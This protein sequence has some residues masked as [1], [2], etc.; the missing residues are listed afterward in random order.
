VLVSS[1]CAR[2]C[3]CVCVCVRVCACVCVC[4]RVCAC[5]CV[6]VRV[7]VTVRQLDTMGLKGPEKQEI[8]YIMENKEHH[9]MDFVPTKKKRCKNKTKQA[10]IFN[11][12]MISHCDGQT[13]AKRVIFPF[14]Y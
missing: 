5:V 10:K 6:C 13:N 9:V 8:T 7:C 1:V 11:Q 3:V 12:R 2:V 14:L 4:V